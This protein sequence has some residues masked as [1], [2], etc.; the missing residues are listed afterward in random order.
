MIEVRRRTRQDHKTRASDYGII[1]AVKR[2]LK[3]VLLAALTIVSAV[4]APM[5]SVASTRVGAVEQCG[6]RGA[7]EEASLD[8]Q[9]WQINH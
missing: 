4:V 2:N 6:L 1:C 8:R 5:R 3:T 7:A 9:L